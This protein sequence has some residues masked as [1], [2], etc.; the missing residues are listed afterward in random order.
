MAR[1]LA[2]LF[3]FVLSPRILYAQINNVRCKWVKVQGTSDLQLDTSTVLP[4]SISVTGGGDSL[5]LTY[6]PNTGKASWSGNS[7]ADSVLVCYRVLSSDLSSRYYKRSLKQYDTL[8][9]FRDDPYYNRQFQGRKEELFSSPGINKTGT[10][11]RG[12]SVG[13]NQ[14]VF[15]NSVLNLQLEGK[16][17]DDVSIIASISDQNIPF[18]P[19]GNTQQLQQF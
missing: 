3:F 4:S 16:L 2:V 11:S 6:D 7:A 10:I 1:L 8:G 14:S 13:N 17:T 19:E 18:Q 15:V 5:R 12:I 9:Y